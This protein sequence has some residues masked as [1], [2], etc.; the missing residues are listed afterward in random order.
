MSLATTTIKVSP[1]VRD[2]LNAL[3]SESGST[4]GSVVEELLEAYIWRQKMD[5]AKK[6]MRAASPEVWNEY[7]AEIASLDGSLSDGL[8]ENPWHP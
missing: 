6:Q 1:E 4:A 2:R 3:A 7:L 5:L 8:E